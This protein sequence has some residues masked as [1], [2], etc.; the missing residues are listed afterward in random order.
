MDERTAKIKHKI[1]R[2]KRQE[3][4]YR[5]GS[6]SISGGELVWDIFFNTNGN[7]Q[8]KYTLDQLAAM[9]REAYRQVVDEFFFHVYYRIYKETFPCGGMFDPE[10]LS[11]FGLPPDADEEAVKKKFRELAKRLHPDAGGDHEQFITLMSRYKRLIP[12]KH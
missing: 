4:Y 3:M 8:A 10:L 9:D 1:R 12:E 6:T 2:L 7:G 11:Q 5:Y